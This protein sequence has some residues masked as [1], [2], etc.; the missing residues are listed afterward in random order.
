MYGPNTLTKQI[1]SGSEPVPS[2]AKPLV[3][4]LTKQ[5]NQQTAKLQ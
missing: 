5:A 1:V 4:A 2:E 3:S